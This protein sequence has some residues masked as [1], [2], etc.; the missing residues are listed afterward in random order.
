MGKPDTAWG[1]ERPEHCPPAEATVK[2]GAALG[3]HVNE[4]SKG[5]GTCEGQ[6]PAFARV[7]TAPREAVFSGNSA[8]SGPIRTGAGPHPGH[9]EEHGG[10]R[11]GA[12]A[13]PHRSRLRVTLETPQ[14]KCH[15]FGANLCFQS[16][17]TLV[18]PSAGS[19]DE[20]YAAG[21]HRPHH[22]PR[23][24]GCRP[25]EDPAGP[26]HRPGGRSPA[27]TRDALRL[28]RTR[29]RA[30]TQ[31]GGRARHLRSGL[32][33]RLARSVSLGLGVPL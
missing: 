11:P 12:C 25:R 32:Q 4:D 29:P 18:A 9:R 28:C 2:L 6:R 30:E 16:A 31:P 23:Q 5:L 13:E 33:A 21:G 3:V 20:P 22:D 10:P 19:A 15:C 7:L 17:N 27:P 1:P 14:G 26:A 8:A 24:L